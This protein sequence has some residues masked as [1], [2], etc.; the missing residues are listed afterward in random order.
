MYPPR[1]QAKQMENKAKSGLL[2]TFC[3]HFLFV[4]GRGALL[5][6][7]YFLVLFVWVAP[8]IAILR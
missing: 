2:C 7:V 3:L 6:L 1:E 4:P 5:F 8:F